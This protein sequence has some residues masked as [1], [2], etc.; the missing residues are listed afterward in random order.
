MLSLLFCFIPTLVLKIPIVLIYFILKF[1]SCLF[2]YFSLI[3]FTLLNKLLL[4][5]TNKYLLKYNKKE[6]KMIPFFETVEFG[7]KKFIICFKKF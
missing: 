2:C 6:I 4:T 7:E 5:M 3:T 1:L